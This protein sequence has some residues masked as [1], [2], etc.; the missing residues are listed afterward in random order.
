MS[1]M[2]QWFPGKQYRPERAGPYQCRIPFP[3]GKTEDDPADHFRWFDKAL[4]WSHPLDYDPELDDE[5]KKPPREE[6]FG[7]QHEEPL[8]LER[9]DWRGYAADQEEL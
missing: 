4:G 7:G 6:F 1:N 3:F 5:I 8:F 2:T 9:F